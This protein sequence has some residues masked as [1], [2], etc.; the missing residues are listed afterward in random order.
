MYQK[1]LKTQLSSHANDVARTTSQLINAQLRMLHVSSVITKV[2]S[3][4]TVETFLGVMSLEGESW[5]CLLKLGNCEISFKL[6]TGAGLYNTWTVDTG[7]DHG[8]DS[9][10]TVMK[11]A[12]P[13][14]KPGA[15]GQRP[16]TPGFLVRAS[17]CV[18]VCV[19]VSAPKA[20]NNQWRDMV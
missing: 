5:F 14:F 1:Q 7:L 15:R 18:C 19:C 2:T 8:L 11:V 17:V 10:L 12:K 20:I 16:H 13:L 3:E 9:G 6:D 4:L